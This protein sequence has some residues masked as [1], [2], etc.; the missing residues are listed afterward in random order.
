MLVRKFPDV[1]DLRPTTLI[2]L[3]GINDWHC[4]KGMSACP[5]GTRR[6]FD[7][8]RDV[9]RHDVGAPQLHSGPVQFQY[10][11]Q[12]F[13][14]EE[15][16]AKSGESENQNRRPSFYNFLLKRLRPCAHSRE[17][18]PQD[19]GSAH[20]AKRDVVGDFSVES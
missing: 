3:A 5:I 14:G 1:I 13:L 18:D 8:C 10:L 6:L 2:L 4:R 19:S 15:G 17:L 11:S 20:A 7:S 9:S 12:A 16:V